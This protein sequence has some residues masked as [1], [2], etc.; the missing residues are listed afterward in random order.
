M[1]MIMLLVRDGCFRVSRHDG[2]GAVV[3]QRTSC[4]SARTKWACSWEHPE[5]GAFTGAVGLFGVRREYRA[6][7]VAAVLAC[8]W[9][10]RPGDGASILSSPQVR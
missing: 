10:D 5:I 4:C 7:A 8:A 9:R 2:H 6:T 1:A 3:T